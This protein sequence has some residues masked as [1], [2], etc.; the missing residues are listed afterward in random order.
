MITLTFNNGLPNRSLKVGDLVYHISNPSF[1]YSTSGF[2]TGDQAGVGLGG[3]STHILIGDLVSIQPFLIED[4]ESVTQ[5]ESQYSFKLFVK[6]ASTLLAAPAAGDY[7]F[8]A[9][10]NLVEQSSILGYYNAVTFTNDSKN[11]AE[12]FAVSCGVDES[13]K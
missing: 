12:L 6:P 5:N 2:I 9:K 8:F 4:P 13:S 7:I 10:N 3:V 11:K 1:N